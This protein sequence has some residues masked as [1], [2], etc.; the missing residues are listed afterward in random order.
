MDTYT[1]TEVDT[2]LYTNSTST[3]FMDSTLQSYLTNNQLSDT[4][5][6]KAE[7]DDLINS[8]SNIFHTKTQIDTIWGI[9]YLAVVDRNPV[10]GSYSR[11]IQIRW[12]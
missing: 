8:D 10:L 4:Y 5:Y 7:I 9:Y 2:L 6:N 11:A 1:N 3:S 12:F